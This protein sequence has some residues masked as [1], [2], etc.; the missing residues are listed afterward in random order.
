MPMIRTDFSLSYTQSGLLMSA[1]SIT[2]GISQ[3]PAGWLADRFESKWMVLVSVSGVALVGFLIGVSHSYTALLVLLVLAAILGGGYHPASVAA[4]SLSVPSEYRGRAFGFH[5]IGG[6]AAFWIVPLL[7]APIAV[8]WGWRS[9]YLTLTIPAI[10]LGVLLYIIIRR[11]SQASE[12][13]I[14]DSDSTTTSA[15]IPWREIAPF[16]IVSVA[17]GTVI[18]SVLAYISLYAVDSLG[19]TEAVAAM[20]VAISPAVSSLVAPVG[21]YLSDRFGNVPVLLAISFCAIPLVYLLGKA[22]NVTI[23]ATLLVAIG[24]VSSGRMPTSESY[25]SSKTPPRRRA[26]LFGIYFFAS[27]EVSGL[28]TPVVGN[29][30][31]R[32]G[33]YS[34]FSMASIV[35][36]AVAVVCSV[37]LWRNRT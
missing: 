23:L 25:I 36:A 12:S 21:G 22:S 19:V 16:V 35:M 2:N 37:F 24:I 32:F 4:I 14:A 13:H 18:Q 6:T 17:I 34:T 8:A 26:T 7:A 30:I 31:D 15:H 3:L 29:L 10:I 33:F 20:L 1:F 11:Q 5:L 9:S 28:L 27:T